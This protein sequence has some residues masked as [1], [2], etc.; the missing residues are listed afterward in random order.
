MAFA[1]QGVV[2]VVETL[3]SYYGSRVDDDD[4]VKGRALIVCVA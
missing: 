4:N 3:S 1:F 2:V